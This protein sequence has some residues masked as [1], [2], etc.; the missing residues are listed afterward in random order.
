MSTRCTRA[1]HYLLLA[2]LGPKVWQ[3]ED[4][5]EEDVEFCARSRPFIELVH[6][7]DI[8]CDVA[9]RLNNSDTA[10]HGIHTSLPVHIRRVVD[11]GL[12]IRH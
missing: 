8:R 5:L 10:A 11:R 3:T 9:N 1:S 7:I 4:L 12:P 6:D 2:E